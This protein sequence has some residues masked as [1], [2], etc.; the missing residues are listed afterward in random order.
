[1]ATK[2]LLIR[3]GSLGDLALT[4]PALWDLA[5]SEPRG[6]RHFLVLAPWASLLTPLPEL[7]RVWTLPRGARSAELAAL[8]RDLAAEA[9]D[10]VLDF[11]GNLR[12]RLLRRQLGRPPAGWWQSPRH[13]LRRR[14][15]VVRPGWPALLRPRAPLPPVWQRHRATLRAALGE[16]YRPAPPAAA[17]YPLSQALRAAVD[18]ELAA[19]GLAPGERPLALAPGA[20]WPAKVWPHAAALVERLSG[21]W[22]LLLVGGPAER[23]TCAALAALGAVDYSGDR[24]LSQVAAA[25][26]RSRALVASDSGLGHL[27]EAVGTPVLDLYGPTVPAFGFAPRLEASRVL[28]RPLG[29][30]PCSLH[31]A[32]PCRFG[33][34]NCLGELGAD[35]VVAELSAM[36]ALA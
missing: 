25:L 24:P 21:R 5:A 36:G 22:P 10:R 33:H 11:H 29:C 12:A 15:M 13:D 17:R 14:L 19:L 34:G 32:R 8:G 6:E 2:T 27:A 7:E 31:G 16:T 35:A 20:A 23:D 9:Y 4:L 28:E 3:F 18:A 26:G 30:R 1:M